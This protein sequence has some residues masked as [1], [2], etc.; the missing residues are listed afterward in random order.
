MLTM[1]G[2][3][4][5]AAQSDGV[6]KSGTGLGALATREGGRVI[7]QVWNYQEAPVSL[8]VSIHDLPTPRAG[9]DLTV[10]QYLIDSTHSNCFADPAAQGGL[11]EVETSRRDYA[12]DLQ[13]SAQLEPM[14]L[15]LWTI[16]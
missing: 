11:E 14:A 4:E 9:R 8:N 1:H 15:S 16:E 7:V 5:I 3:Q 10:R 13:F 6:T 12:A 2:G